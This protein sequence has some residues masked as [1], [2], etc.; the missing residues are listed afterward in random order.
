MILSG[1]CFS[2]WALS[3]SDRTE[4][5]EAGAGSTVVDHNTSLPPFYGVLLSLKAYHSN[6]P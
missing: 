2:K 3:L 4:I 6:N 1:E 5:I